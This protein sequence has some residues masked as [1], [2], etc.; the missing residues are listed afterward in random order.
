MLKLQFSAQID[1]VTAK[2]DKTLSIR[3]GTQELTSDDTSHIFDLMG[4]QVWLAIAETSIESLEVPELLPEMKGDKSP[5]QRLR[6]VL[7]K[8]WEQ[9]MDGMDI[10]SVGY[11][12]FP[13]FYEDYI[14]R[15]CESLKDKIN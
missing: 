13:R 5:S 6:G 9:K 14:F 7:Y 4:K 15:L 11:Q 1:G 8:L 2:K 10:R 3:L 12:T